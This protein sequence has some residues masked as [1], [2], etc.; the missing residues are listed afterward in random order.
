M[1]KHKP[2]QP[3]Q[4]ENQ[5]DEDA[6]AFA[7]GIFELAR[8][9]GTHMLRPMLEAGVP[10]NIRTSNGESL[11]MLAARNGH[12]DTVQL[13][14]EKGANPELQDADGNTALSLARAMGAQDVIKHLDR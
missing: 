12:V 6:I 8:N 5:L 11:L 4:P 1:S 9:G 10:V 3:Q 2:G 14:L 13:L 7:Q